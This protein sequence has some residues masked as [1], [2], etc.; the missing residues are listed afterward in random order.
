MV[1]GFWRQEIE[2]VRKAMGF[3]LPAEIHFDSIIL[4]D[5]SAQKKLLMDLV[6]RG[7]MSDETLLE[8]MREIPSIE[9]VRTKREQAE[10]ANQSVPNKAGPYHNPQH[11]EDMAK[12]AMTKDVL[13]SEEYLQEGLGLPYKEPPAPPVAPQKEQSGP[14]DKS[15]PPQDAGRPKNSTDTNPRKQRRVLPRSSEPTS[16]TL[17]GIEAQEKIAK[18]MNAFACKNFGKSTARELN[19]AEVDQ[20][21]YLKLCIFTGLDPMIEVTPDIIKDVLALNTKPSIA[22]LKLSEGKAVTFNTVMKRKPNVSEM[23]HI[24]ASAF[25]EIFCSWAE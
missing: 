4:S 18:H 20:L 21:E 12:I 5:E 15:S 9:K 23:R 1:A 10:R 24:Y 6:D 3:R 16:A 7:I 2:F 19:K 8:R 11:K 17:W 13:D 25:A 22:F 14:S